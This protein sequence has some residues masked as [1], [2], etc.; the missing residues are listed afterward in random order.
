MKKKI[1]TG[2]RENSINK[3]TLAFCVLTVVLSTASLTFVQAK[4]TKT[5]K[6][7]PAQTTIFE[8]SSNSKMEMP[9]GQRPNKKPDAKP[10]GDKV[11]PEFA[12]TKNSVKP[13]DKNNSSEKVN[14]NDEEN[15]YKFYPSANMNRQSPYPP[16]NY[17]GN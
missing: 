15:I 9:K 1:F 17:K 2:T 4:T 13:T 14:N 16:A 12:S 7:L 3:K 6:T 8:Q 5:N 11:P 10:G